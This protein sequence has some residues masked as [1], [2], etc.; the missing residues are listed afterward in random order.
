M[1]LR[2]V[3][4]PV[5]AAM[6]AACDVSYR[7]AQISVATANAQTVLRMIFPSYFTHPLLGEGRHGSIIPN[8]GRVRSGAAA[9]VVLKTTTLRADPSWVAGPKGQKE[10]AST[11]C[12]GPEAERVMT[13]VTP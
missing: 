9:C 4:I 5:G 13:T 2:P 1:S 10:R 3:C 6:G 8:P 11:G 12:R 7:A